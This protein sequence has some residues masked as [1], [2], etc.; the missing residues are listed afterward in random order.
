MYCAGQAFTNIELEMLRSLGIGEKVLSFAVDDKR[1]ASLYRKALLFIFPSFYEGFGMPILEAM[2]CNCPVLLSNVSCFPEVAG[3]AG[4]YFDPYSID[5][6][7][8][9]MEYVIE[10]PTYRDEL[11]QKGSE[12]VKDFSWE[13]CAEEHLKVYQSLI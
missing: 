4:C 9:K 6:M 2:S 13:R 3:D 7:T 8:E 12:R 5:D 1:L 10:H 11:I